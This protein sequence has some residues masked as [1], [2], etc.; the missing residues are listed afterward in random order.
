MDTGAVTT[1][2][3]AVTASVA[4]NETPVSSWNTRQMRSAASVLC[5][6]R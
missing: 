5:R 6:G 2:S 1:A 4:W 3:A